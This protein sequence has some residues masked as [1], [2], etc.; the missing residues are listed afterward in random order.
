L[1]LLISTDPENEAR[2][3]QA[4]ES[5]PDKAV[6][7]LKPGETARYKVIHVAD[8]VIVEPFAPA[9]DSKIRHA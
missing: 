3:F 5:L 2:V 1:D 7:E 6:G 8:E 9:G 4:L